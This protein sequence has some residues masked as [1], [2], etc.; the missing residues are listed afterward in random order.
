IKTG[1]P[2]KGR[3]MKNK[4]LKKEMLPHYREDL[5]NY[6]GLLTNNN[7]E[8]PSF[9]AY[10]TNKIVE[11]PLAELDEKSLRFCY[12]GDYDT[13]DMLYNRKRHSDLGK[14]QQQILTQLNRKMAEHALTYYGNKEVDQYRK[15]RI[16]SSTENWDEPFSFVRHGDQNSYIPHLLEAKEALFL[17]HREVDEINEVMCIIMDYLFTEMVFAAANGNIYHIETAKECFEFYRFFELENCMPTLGLT[18]E[19]QKDLC[20]F[21]DNNELTHSERYDLL[22]ANSDMNYFNQYFYSLIFL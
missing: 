14:T 19:F 15:E 12:T 11:V 17:N 22:K 1:A 18:R 8:N 4:T 21:L 16:F 3:E 9:F 5:S 6:L 7:K 2:C 20:N 10:L 13:C